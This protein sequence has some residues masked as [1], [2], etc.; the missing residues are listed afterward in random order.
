MNQWKREDEVGNESHM[1]RGD[2]VRAAFEASSDL[3]SPDVAESLRL[4]KSLGIPENV[5]LEQRNWAVQ[6][7]KARTVEKNPLLAQWAEED[8][9]NAAFVRDDPDALLDLFEDIQIERRDEENRKRYWEE[10]H[11]SI[12]QRYEGPLE[13]IPLLLE[14][15]LRDVGYS[16]GGFISG[17]ARFLGNGT[18]TDSEGNVHPYRSNLLDSFADRVEKNLLEK[19]KA[20]PA[21]L[22]A[23]TEIGGYAQDVI[24]Q[25]PQL[26]AQ[27]LATVGT[28]GLGGVSFMGSQIAGGQYLDLRERGVE[29]DLSLI[30]I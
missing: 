19:R 16:V 21:R 30:H 28:G 6:E 15:G 23:E 20:D 3:S 2:G 10:R 22:Q 1:N 24:R 9:K 12:R 18:F 14:E 8:R 27:I 17:A 29:A 11:G 4:A 13:Q 25:I 26:G 7:E 5:V